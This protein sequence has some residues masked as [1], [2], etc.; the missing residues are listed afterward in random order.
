M[1]TKHTPSVSSAEQYL[2]E[3][4]QYEAFRQEC[5]ALFSRSES[6]L[7][8]SVITWNSRALKARLMQTLVDCN[9]SRKR[10]ATKKL[11]QNLKYDCL[12]SGYST[13]SEEVVTRKEVPIEVACCNSL[14]KTERTVFRGLHGG[15]NVSI[16][17]Q[18][19]NMNPRYASHQILVSNKQ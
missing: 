2:Q 14:K 18:Y 5:G 12:V 13:M 8:V 1:H 4:T 11:F 7:H 16:R 6:V 15:E 9:S 17:P 3:I 10:R 19:H